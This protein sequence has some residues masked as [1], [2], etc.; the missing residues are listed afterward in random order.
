MLE[1]C[2]VFIIMISPSSTSS[3]WVMKELDIA[4]VEGKRIIPVLYQQANVRTDLRAIQYISFLDSTHKVAFDK[5]V[6]ALKR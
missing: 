3:K 6:Q 1:Q 5:L 2:D 4:T